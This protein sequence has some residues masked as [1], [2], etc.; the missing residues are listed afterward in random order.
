VLNTIRDQAT[1]AELHSDLRGIELL[2][3]LATPPARKALEALADGAAGARITME[4]A[5]ALKR[6]ASGK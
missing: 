1:P 4:A 6:V 3:T 5:S 2:E